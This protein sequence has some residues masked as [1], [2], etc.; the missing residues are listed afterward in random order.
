MLAPSAPPHPCVKDTIHH[1]LREQVV[2]EGGE[3]WKLRT[4]LS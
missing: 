4:T 2:E 3:P 1:V